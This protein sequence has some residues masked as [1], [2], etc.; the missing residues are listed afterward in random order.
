V[1]DP[2]IFLIKVVAIVFHVWLL[3][4]MFSFY[5]EMKNKQGLRYEAIFN[6]MAWAP[7]VYVWLLPLTLVYIIFQLS[8][9]SLSAILDVVR[10]GHI[11]S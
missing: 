2:N 11:L 5:K 1:D 8:L 4:W 6:R 9:V 10:W 3:K 7:K